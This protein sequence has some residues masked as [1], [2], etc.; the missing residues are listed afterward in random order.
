MTL[1]RML[2]TPENVDRLSREFGL[3]EEQTLQAVSALL[4]AFSEG[5]K[6]QTASPKGTAD[7]LAAL[8]DGRHAGYIEDP[9]T[10]VTKSGIRDGKGILGH[11][12]GNKDVSRAVAS[13]A[14]AA[15]GLSDSLLKKMLPV[16][17]SMVMG[18]LFKG[19]KGGKLGEALGEAAGGGM[20]GTIVESLA[21]GFIGGAT[22]GTQTRRRRRNGGLLEDLLGGALGGSGRS[23]TRQRRPPTRTKTRSRRTPRSSG[24][25]LGDLLGD[26]LGGGRPRRSGSARR[27]DPVMPPRRTRPTRRRTVRPKDVFGDML[28]PGVDASRNYRRETRDVF[29]QL[30]GN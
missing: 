12:F 9:A 29:D 2:L 10:A 24:G 26:L 23:R 14:S 7:L 21:D 16:L 20:L 27:S 30:L 6:R 4:P 17:A 18:A 28:E 5:L 3:S 25:G 1:A 19:A 11:L 15:S 13:R 8:A 22:R